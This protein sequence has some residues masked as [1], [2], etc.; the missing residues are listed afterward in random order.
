MTRR[1]VAMRFPPHP[2]DPDSEALEYPGS[3]IPPTITVLV[4]DRQAVATGLYDASGAQLYAV[5][6]SEPAGFVRFVP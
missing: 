2:M 1:Y 3:A 6:E 5:E 4:P